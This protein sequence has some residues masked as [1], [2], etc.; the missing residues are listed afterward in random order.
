MS[1]T[2]RRYGLGL[3]LTFCLPVISVASDPAANGMQPAA[4]AFLDKNCSVC[5]R[6]TSAPAGID[7]KAL[8]FNLDD[9]NTFGTWVRVYDAVKSGKMPKAGIVV[10]PADR[11]LFLQTIARPMIAHDERKAETQGR[12]VLRRLNRYEYENSLRDLLS[13]PWLQMRDS[14][15]EDG[16]VDRLN[17]I[18]QGLDI[19]HVQMAQYF[20]TAGKEIRLVLDSIDYPENTSRYYARQQKSFIGRMRIQRPTGFGIQELSH[21]R[22]TIPILGFEGQPDVLAGKAPMTA[23]AADPMTRDLEAFVTTVSTYIGGLYQFDG[24]SAPVGGR[25]HLSFNAYSIWVGTSLR[26]EKTVSAAPGVDAWRPDLNH[27]KTSRGRTT[28]P[29][30]IYALNSEGD[31]RLLG[32]FDAGPEPGTHDI[33]VYLLPGETIR[34]DAARLWRPGVGFVQSTDAS[35]QGMPGVAYRWMDV[36]GPV[37]DT[38]AR[39]RQRLLFGGLDHGSG[40]GDAARL[41]RL[42]IEKAYRRPPAE[43]EVQRYVKIVDARLGEGFKQ[44]MIDGYTAVL[45]SPGFLFLEEKPGPLDS[46]ALASRLS[47]FLWNAPPDDQLLQLAAE[48]KLQ[49]PAV[50][51]AQTNRLLDSPRSR[52][53]VDAF[54]DYWLDLRKMV[55]NA[56]DEKLYPDYYLDDMLAESSLQETQLFFS[57]LLKK[58]LPVRN[59]ISSDF[60]IL[61]SRLASHYG[62]PAVDGVAMRYVEL[63]R[64]TVRGGL[65]T[66]ASVLRVTANGTTT[67]PV[68]RGAWI[69]ER[70]LGEPSPPPPPGV[71]AID[72]DTRGAT[73]IRQQLDKHRSAATC[74]VCHTRID[75][76]GFALENFDVFGGWRDRYRSTQQGDPALGF[77]KDGLPFTFRKSQPVDVSGQLA[78][79]EKFQ[80]IIGLKAL[81]LKDERQIARNMVRQFVAYGSGAP[82]SFGDRPEVERILD[83]SAADHFGMRTLIQQVVLSKLFIDK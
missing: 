35:E 10:P 30:T 64:N 19:S 20:E 41:L 72:P 47:Y 22:A 74:A 69:L 15:P 24:F 68:T 59:I 61:N 45:C 82:V 81:L 46:Y 56:P 21:E 73:T 83:S 76:P 4:R 77:G 71:A 6:G 55:E 23:G 29:L 11:A 34:P 18:G 48:G 7:L 3:L 50:L 17:K 58:D 9:I 75:P 37:P 57:Y 79:G 51:R 70:I 26:T 65:L 78:G 52:D 13:A 31:T 62:L 27:L 53:F 66:Q 40:P 49:N 33:D 63:P 44:A 67:S 2:T 36:T 5:H 1:C 8:P 42:F 16:L 43:E 14:L 32:S 38:A 25:Y 12:A 54:L 80:D 60:S 39:E 28:E